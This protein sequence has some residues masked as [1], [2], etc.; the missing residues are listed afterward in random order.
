MCALSRLSPVTLWIVA[1]QG[2]SVPGILQARIPSSRGSSQPGDQAGN[3]Y[4]SRTPGRFFTAE[5]L[6]IL[7]ATTKTRTQR[8]LLKR[9]LLES[10]RNKSAYFPLLSNCVL[11]S[12]NYNLNAHYFSSG[13]T[14]SP[15]S[16]I[17]LI[18]TSLNKY[19]KWFLTK[20]RM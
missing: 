10:K 8:G 6:V 16:P 12:S 7:R 5:L 11:Q 19:L 13:Q 4:S 3:C 2:S 14:S 9:E 15:A 20:T 1:C 17:H 18:F